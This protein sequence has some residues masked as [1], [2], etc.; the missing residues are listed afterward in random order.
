MPKNQAFPREFQ[1]HGGE[2]PSIGEGAPAFMRGRSALALRKKRQIKRCAL[3]PGTSQLTSRA[4]R[5]HSARRQKYDI[6]K[7]A[8]AGRKKIQ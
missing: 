2:S 6:L 4:A 7:T 8:N 5:Q 1:L 3:A